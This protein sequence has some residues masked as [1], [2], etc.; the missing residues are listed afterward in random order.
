MYKIL[1][2]LMVQKCINMT[3]KQTVN[4]H[5]CRRN[6]RCYH[7]AH[8][9][10]AGTQLRRFSQKVFNSD[11]SSDSDSDFIHSFIP[12]ACAECDTSLPFSE[13]SAISLHYIPFPSTPLHQLVFHPPSLHT[14]TY[15]L[16][17]LSARLFPNSN[18]IL[19]W[20]FY[21]LPFSVQTNT[22]YLTLLSLL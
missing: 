16:V 3:F 12:L 18:I 6:K 13:V 7:V 19:F 9:L 14:T 20:E 4:S 21:F 5:I 1:L 22:I 17:Y 8:P 11:S 15:F 10:R 2:H